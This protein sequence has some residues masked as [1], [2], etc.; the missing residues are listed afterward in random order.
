MKILHRLRREAA[1]RQGTSPEASEAVE[2]LLEEYSL[3]QR[4]EGTSGE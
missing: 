3:K 2:S 1:N 4:D